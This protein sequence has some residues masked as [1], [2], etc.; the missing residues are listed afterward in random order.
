MK[1][2]VI[3]FI[4]T[5]IILL[6]SVSIGVYVLRLMILRKGDLFGRN[7]SITTEQTT[8]TEKSGSKTKAALETDDYTGTMWIGDSRYVGMDKA[9][10]IESQD[11][12]FVVAKIGQGLPWFKNTA[13]KTVNKIRKQNSALKTWR[14]VI[15]LG[16]NDLGDINNYIEEYKT[17]TEED[18]SIRLVLVSVNP[19]KDYPSISNK[20]VQ[21]FN[22]KLKDAC[23]ENDWYYIDTYSKLMKSG[24]TTTDGLHY[25]DETYQ[26]IYDGIKEGL[27]EYEE[28]KD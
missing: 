24:Y 5:L 22:E 15:C 20:D 26:E 10:D 4:V 25:N 17:L 6:L 19:V 16:V 11:R 12:N 28:K 27:S 13:L 14:Y 18:P 7:G 21:S 9:V 1:K 23:D 2:T 8:K 3:E